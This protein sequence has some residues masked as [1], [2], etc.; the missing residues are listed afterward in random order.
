MDEYQ[1]NIVC[2]YFLGSLK[3]I[4]QSIGQSGHYLKVKVTY[5]MIVQ[6]KNFN[7]DLQ[8]NLISSPFQIIV[9]MSSIFNF[10]MFKLIY[11]TLPMLIY[12]VNQYCLFHF[13]FE[14]F[15][16]SK[17]F[18]PFLAICINLVVGWYMQNWFKYYCHFSPFFTKIWICNNF[19][20]LLWVLWIITNNTLSG[21]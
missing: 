3:L 13:T 11:P 16:T 17:I 18:I 4:G 10:Q 12:V 19:P 8:N 14:S 21:L 15:P 2:E 9:S 1:W 7:I 6:F 20:S 5:I